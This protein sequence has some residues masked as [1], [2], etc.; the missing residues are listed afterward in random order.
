MSIKTLGY[1]QQTQIMTTGKSH[2]PCWQAL[3]GSETCRQPGGPVCSG[4]E[5][6]RRMGWASGRSN[7]CDPPTPTPDPGAPALESRP[8]DKLWGQNVSHMPPAGCHRGGE[9]EDTG[10]ETA[11]ICYRSETIFKNCGNV[12]RYL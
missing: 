6:T 8:G 11:N 4:Q 3:Q 1:K 12:W 2:A 9:R 10:L 5:H 7:S